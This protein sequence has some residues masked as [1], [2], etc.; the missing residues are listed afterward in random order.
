MRNAGVTPALSVVL[1]IHAPARVGDAGEVQERFRG[2]DSIKAAE[3]KIQRILLDLE[4]EVG[5][6][7]EVRVDTRPFANLVVEI[8]VFDAAVRARG[9]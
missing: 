1:G 9:D 5:E 8:F 3:K 4:E 2:E 6:L 7:D